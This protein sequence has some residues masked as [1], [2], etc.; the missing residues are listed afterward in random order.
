VTIKFETYNSTSSKT[1]GLCLPA[2]CDESDI[3]LLSAA[4]FAVFY[5]KIVAPQNF[6]SVECLAPFSFH[7]AGATFIV[8][9]VSILALFVLIGTVRSYI[10][11][12][13]FEK[14]SL[15]QTVNDG[16]D[17]KLISAD[18]KAIVQP[19]QPVPKRKNSMSV[20]G[21]FDLAQNWKDLTKSPSIN[22][23]L[24]ALDGLRFLSMC[25]IIMAHTTLHAELNSMD[26]LGL[27]RQYTARF[28]TQL[29]Y[30]ATLAVDTF[31]VLS[32][33]LA[34]YLFLDSFAKAKAA[35]AASGKKKREPNI[36]AW[37]GLV[38]FHRYLRLTPLYFVA[39]M[40]YTYVI[41]IVSNGPYWNKFLTTTD[42]T[43]PCTK[44]WWT[45]MLYINNF[46]P[47]QFGKDAEGG[48]GCMSWTWYLANDTQLF[49]I[50][51]FIMKLYM[52]SRRAA[53]AVV[54]VLS[55]ITIALRGILVQY[56]DLQAC[57]GALSASSAH[58]ENLD[59]TAI[60]NK[61]YTRAYPYL[62]GIALSFF[63]FEMG[64]A[65]NTR[66]IHI[67]KPMYVALWSAVALVMGLCVWGSYGMWTPSGPNAG[68]C[69]WNA[70]QNFMGMTFTSI[71]WSSCIVFIVFMGLFGHGGWVTK[72][73][74]LDAFCP[75]SR[76][77][78]AAYL[79][80]P[81]L[82]YV[83]DFSG[84][85]QYDFYDMRIAIDFLGMAVG[86]FAVALLGHL[87]VEKPM[88]NVQKI[89]LPAGR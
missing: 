5:D 85:T 50:L 1:T 49:L 65:K 54:I 19:M 63:Y 24:K 61:P 21:A 81:M 74:A 73:L 16:E 41:P 55:V 10:L 88:I 20:L 62:A 60:Y 31:F 51:P 77:V 25:W 75:V 84:S 2:H 36:F 58:A 66:K 45:N 68:N 7:G 17:E 12:L 44:Y 6:T 46:Y 59:Q 35:E 67:S 43:A 32:S 87:L 8:V 39:I 18:G 26:I 14:K 70:S 47:S 15:V 89:I 71:A 52:S 56:Y 30:N 53:W 57:L 13:K 28:A 37:S 72:I 11:Q 86:S 33:F 78:Y 79:V 29:P 38:Y 27:S 83:L 42:V 69:T 34:G 22:N 64:G 23:G 3:R 48:L 80:H 76:L 82:M 4:Y 40:F 9:L